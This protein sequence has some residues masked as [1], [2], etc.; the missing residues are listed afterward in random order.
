MES[1]NRA[2]IF[3]PW[4]LKQM[5]LESME[6]YSFNRAMIFQPW[7]HPNGYL[8]FHEYIIASIGP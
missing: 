6:K 4:K 8:F 3:Q 2:M 7:K 1:F 5:A